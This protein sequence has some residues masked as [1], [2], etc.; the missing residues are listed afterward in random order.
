MSFNVKEF[1]ERAKA[2]A[3]KE[4]AAAGRAPAQAPAPAAKPT[5]DKIASLKEKIQTKLAE[6]K[7]AQAAAPAG[8]AD[9]QARLKAFKENLITKRRAAKLQEN[10]VARNTAAKETGR[11]LKEET[12]LL[13]KRVQNLKNWFKE[14]EGVLGAGV[15]PYAAGTIPGQAVPGLEPS[16]DPNAPAQPPVQLPPEVVAEIQSIATAAESLAQL[17]GIEPATNLGAEPGSDVPATTADGEGGALPQA[18]PGVNPVLESIRKR[19]IDSIKEKLAARKAESLA[20]KKTTEDDEIAALQEKAAKRR[21][22]LQELRAKVMAESFNDQ[23][24]TDDLVQALEIN[25]SYPYPTAPKYTD[26]SE[27]L[28][29]AG[30]KRGNET[31]SFTPGKN[32]LKPGHV[33]KPGTLKVS[34]STK[35]LQIHNQS[36]DAPEG[37]A[38]R[39]DGQLDPENWADRHVLKMTESKVDFQALLK[40]G[41]LG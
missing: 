35:E 37:T 41:L 20:E 39:E 10:R 22:A 23:E 6:K 40:K 17:A 33:W 24:A 27:V 4:A 9:R 26:R 13:K 1:K 19:K 15:D 34:G 36:A 8:D 30:T 21:A 32:T 28:P 3:L 11:N 16:M 12:L 25:P 14:N 7:A 5:N 2:A 18:Q 38:L 31:G 29:T